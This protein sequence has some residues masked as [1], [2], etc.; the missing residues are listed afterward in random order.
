MCIHTHTSA[1]DPSLAAET[2]TSSSEASSGPVIGLP[3]GG[4][5]IMLTQAGIMHSVP[6]TVHYKVCVLFSK[7]L[8]K[9]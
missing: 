8:L 2:S 1:S 5:R 7:S 6:I 3:N 4:Q 9:G